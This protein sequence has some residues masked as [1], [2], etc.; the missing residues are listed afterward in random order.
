[1]PPERKFDPTIQDPHRVVQCTAKP[2]AFWAQH[3]NG[4]FRTVN[5]GREWTE[6]ANAAPS[7][8]G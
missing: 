8:F 1:M 6:V 4:V 2:D 3:H 5:G 7:T